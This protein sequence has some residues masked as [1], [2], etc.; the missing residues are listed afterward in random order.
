MLRKT[1]P[2]LYS[3]DWKSSVDVGCESGMG[4]RQIMR[5]SGMQ[6]PSKL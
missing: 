3:G 1:V 5:R 2:D 6:M 4:K